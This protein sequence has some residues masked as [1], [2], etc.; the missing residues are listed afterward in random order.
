MPR[1]HRPWA[2]P[3]V[4]PVSMPSGSARAFAHDHAPSSPRDAPGSCPRYAPVN[5][6]SAPVYAPGDSIGQP[7]R[8]SWSIHAPDDSNNHV[9]ARGMPVVTGAWARG[10]VPQRRSAD[11]GAHGIGAR[12]DLA[13]P[14]PRCSSTTGSMVSS[15]LAA[16]VA[17][18]PRSRIS[19]GA[20]AVPERRQSSWRHSLANRASLWVVSA[21]AG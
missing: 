3:R 18:L 2:M 4:Q 13:S 1:V 15:P 10:F 12:H 5:P 19:I 6:R 9:Q 7:G 20:N 14:W 16:R 21:V 8:T 11:V 17:R